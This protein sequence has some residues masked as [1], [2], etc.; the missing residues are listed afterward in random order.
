MYFHRRLIEVRGACWDFT[1]LPSIDEDDDDF[2]PKPL[3]SE[4]DD[5]ENGNYP[6][7]NQTAGGWDRPAGCRY[8]SKLYTRDAQIF[9]NIYFPLYPNFI[10]IYPNITKDANILNYSPHHICLFVE[11]NHP[12]SFIFIAKASWVDFQFPVFFDLTFC[13]HWS[14]LCALNI[15]KVSSLLC[16]QFHEKSH[17]LGNNQRVNPSPRIPLLLHLLFFLPHPTST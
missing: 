9:Y 5:E 3:S 4:S 17:W 16:Q 13:K 14:N 2:W 15:V 12:P 7:D 6:F 8:I 11:W 1:F 10:Q